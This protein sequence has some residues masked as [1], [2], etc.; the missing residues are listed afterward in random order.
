VLQA[1]MNYTVDILLSV[2][3]MAGSVIGAQFGVGFSERFKAEQLRALLALIVLAV[4]VRMS[5]G[6]V[7]APA[8]VFS[9]GVPR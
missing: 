2:P 7:V 5:L 3:L 8:D 1:A 4:A 6:L 9:I